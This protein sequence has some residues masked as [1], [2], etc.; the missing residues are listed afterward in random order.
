MY[1]C[2]YVFY[3]RT[4]KGALVDDRLPVSAMDTAQF[5]RK[6]GQCQW[7]CGNMSRLLVALIKASGEIS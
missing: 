6:P 2:M 7:P 3:T 1:V 4:G 5:R